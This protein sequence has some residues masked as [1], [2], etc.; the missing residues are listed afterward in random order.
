MVFV[1]APSDADLAVFAFELVFFEDDVEDACHAFGVVFGGG[2]GDDLDP[3]DAACGNLFK[4]A[5]GRAA[6]HAAGSA[7]DQYGDVA[8]STKAEVAVDV[9]IDAR[10]VAQQLGGV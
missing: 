3:V 10:D 9:D 6:C 2:A 5:L 7:V 8:R 1:G 4:Q